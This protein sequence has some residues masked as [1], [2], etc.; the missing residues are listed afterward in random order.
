VTPKIT[1][2][3][4]RTVLLP[5]GEQA[6]APYDR[7]CGACRSPWV[8]EVDQGL[9]NGLT[10]AAIRSSLAGRQ[11]GA[12][13]ERIIRVHIAHLA[14]GQREVRQLLEDPGRLQVDTSD[15]LD[16]I[17]ARGWR[18]MAEGM[19]EVSS[20]DL[21]RAMALKAKID[22]QQQAHASAEAW[23]AAFMAFFEIVRRYLP[24]ADWAAF[25]AECYSNREIL[26]VSGGTS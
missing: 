18:A 23:Q 2:L 1:T 8:A 20:A 6:D 7:T 24:P 15:L 14:D 25:Q 16:Q 19:M 21:M 17:Y 3:P 26:A 22:A 5:S 10:P 11:P 4:T 9:I 12:P 13:N